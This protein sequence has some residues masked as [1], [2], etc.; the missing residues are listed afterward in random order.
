MTMTNAATA[1]PCT[2]NNGNVTLDQPITVKVKVCPE[3]TPAKSVVLKPSGH[4]SPF[5]PPDRVPIESNALPSLEKVARGLHAGSA[6]CSIP[7]QSVHQFAIAT[8]RP[9]TSTALSGH[10]SNTAQWWR[11]HR[12]LKAGP[13]YVPVHPALA[14]THVMKAMIRSQC[15]LQ[16]QAFAPTTAASL[17]TAT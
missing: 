12:T 4:P 13:V 10:R 6:N 5:S 15:F 11:S 7:T 3:A 1:I 17:I 9:L 14:T 8:C 2:N 16:G